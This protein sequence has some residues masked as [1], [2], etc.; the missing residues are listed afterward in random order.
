M[1]KA[2]GRFRIGE[3]SFL[4]PPIAPG[5]HLVATPIGNLWDVTLRALQTLAAADAVYCEDTRVTSRLL[6]RYGIET[7]LRTYH[8]HNATR[9]RPQMLAALAEGQALALVSDAGTPLVSDPGYKLVR[10]AVEAG[11]AVHMAPGPSA[12]LMALALSGL[13]T[14]RFLFVGFLPPKQQAR[15][16]LLSSLAEAGTFVAFD[17]APRIAETLADIA[18]LLGDPPVA[19]GRELTKLHEEMLRGRA[20]EVL[21]RIRGRETLKGEITLVVS[22]EPAERSAADVDAA[23]AEALERLPPAR[24][25]AEIAQRF[26]VAKRDLYARALKLKGEGD[27]DA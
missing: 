23:L 27:G 13:P 17:T 5:L 4:A 14:D 8:D 7:R 24:A 10:E 22:P 21:E 20:S 9:T 11:L 1:N 25:A 26:G 18:E 16:T 12:P 19:V 3:H 2:Q 15:R 6:Q